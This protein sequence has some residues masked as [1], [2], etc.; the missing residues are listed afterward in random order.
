M[1][2]YKFVETRKVEGKLDALVN[3]VTQIAM[4][5]KSASIMEGKLD[6]LVNLVTQLSVNQKS[7]SVARVFGNRSSNDHHTNECPSLQQSGMNEHLEANA[8]NIYS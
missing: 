2:T 8:G 1:A 6:A 7:T 4:S 3:L 5:Q